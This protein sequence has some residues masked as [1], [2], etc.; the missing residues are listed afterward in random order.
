MSMP[1]LVGPPGEVRMTVTITRAATGKVETYEVVGKV[2]PEQLEQLG[3]G[4]LAPAEG[5]K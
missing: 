2:T 1:D 4:H 3:I 5:D